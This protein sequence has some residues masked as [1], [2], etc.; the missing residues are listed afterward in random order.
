MA[1]IESGVHMAMKYPPPRESTPIITMS[2]FI[3]GS[4]SPTAPPRSSSTGLERPTR[5]RFKSSVRKIITAKNTVVLRTAGSCTE[6][7]KGAGRRI[8]E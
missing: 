3:L 8:S 2:Q 4:F 7:P 1:H 6:K 5:Q